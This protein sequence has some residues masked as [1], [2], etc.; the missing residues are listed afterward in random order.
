M[1]KFK[2]GDPALTLVP[3]SILPAGSVV[4]LEEPILPG[5]NLGTQRD[6]VILGADGWWCWHGVIG[7]G[8]PFREKSLMPLRGDFSRERE[9]ADAGELE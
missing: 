5:D 1:A 8:L 9:D 3:L 2:A 6:P 4:V 7:G